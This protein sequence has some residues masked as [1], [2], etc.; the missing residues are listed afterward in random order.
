MR[1]STLTALLF[2]FLAP[3]AA[4]QSQDFGEFEVH[5]NTMPT[6]LLNAD[7]A[8]AYGITRS[9]SRALLNI[10][11]MRRS[12]E[13]LPEAITAEVSATATN[14]NG[15]LTSIRMREVREEDAIYYLGELRVSHEE[16]FSFDVTVIVDGDATPRNVR[17]RQQ[18]FTD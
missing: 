15:Q 4:Q 14:L 2:A 17:F 1:T 8:R 18:F 12:G 13:G 10:A 5:Y 7:V 11:V 9:R 16:T 6:E 3:V